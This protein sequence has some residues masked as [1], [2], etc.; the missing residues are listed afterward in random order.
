[1]C[2]EDTESR[3]NEPEKDENRPSQAP[4]S[5]T[6]WDQYINQ[7]V[8][9]KEP[10]KQPDTVQ[11]LRAPDDVADIEDDI[12][13]PVNLKLDEIQDRLNRLFEEFQGKIKYDVHKE[14]IIDELHRELQGYK[15][16]IVKKH[17]KTMIMDIIQ[18]IDNMRKLA[19]HYQTQETGEIDPEKILNI[20]GSIPSDLE[21]LCFRQGVVPF[22]GETDSFNPARQ[23]VLKRI[24]TPEKE[25]D[26]TIAE[27]MRPGYEW[28]GTVI[29]PEMVAVYTY[30]A[31]PVPEEVRSS[32]E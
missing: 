6:V 28:D 1:M 15:D 32:D 8:P 25:K 20:L 16:D 29:R 19:Q 13:D 7:P 3:P 4:N 5:E 26:R 18:F 30:K 2:P 17:L 10:V 24:E 27:S 9:E 11:H 14:K 12:L 21:D 23:R 22:S 31:T